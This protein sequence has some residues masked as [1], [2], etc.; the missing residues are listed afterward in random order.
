MEHG[1]K[2][3]FGRRKTTVQWTNILMSERNGDYDD[4]DWPI[5]GENC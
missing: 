5:L 4:D 3:S 1:E 2:L